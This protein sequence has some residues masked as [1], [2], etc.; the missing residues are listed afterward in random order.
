MDN[1]A[2]IGG[3]TAVGVDNT[4]AYRPSGYFVLSVLVPDDDISCLV[5][6]GIE[7]GVLCRRCY[8]RVALARENDEEK[9]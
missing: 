3:G 2:S 9:E 5:G 8:R 7:N 1:P 4:F 6:G